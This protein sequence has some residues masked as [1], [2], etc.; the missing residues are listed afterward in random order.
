MFYK[1]I[2]LFYEPAEQC[3]QITG[4]MSSN[5]SEMSSFQIAFLCG[6]LREKKPCK[7]LEI[8]VAGGG[9]TAVI[10]KCMKMLDYSAEMYS[11]DISEKWYRTGNV[12]TGFV[13]KKYMEEIV[14]KVSH[15]F[16]LGKAIPYVIEE[17]GRDIDFLI[18]D[19]T[20]VIPGE[21]LDFLICYPFL[22][23]GCIVVLHDM[24]NNLL[25]CNENSIATRLLFCIVQ[26]S[27]WYMKEEDPD[28][29]GLSNIAAFEVSEGA[30]GYINNIFSALSF[31]W[32]YDLDK[33]SEKYKEIIDKNYGKECAE[34]FEQI[35]QI[36]RYAYIKKSID[37]H[38]RMSHEFLRMK[39]KEQEIVFLYGNGYWS[40]IYSE[41]AKINHL[42]ISGY[43][44]SDDQDLVGVKGDKLVFRLK[45]LPYLPEECSFVLALEHKHFAQVRRNLANK[46]YYKIL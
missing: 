19:T 17:I 46:G 4:N 6:M 7:I 3:D 28:T 5:Y 10:L 43:V 8:G 41:Y 30:K 15:K 39:W 44:I 33:D 21:L 42:P 25:S 22:Q 29:F 11:V 18:L 12:D 27:K 20:H 31:T 23:N 24:I 37:H 2:D 13:A 26:E 36:Q 16:V 34:Y 1:N 38:Y 40:N 35:L 9:T 32:L 14:G 45:D